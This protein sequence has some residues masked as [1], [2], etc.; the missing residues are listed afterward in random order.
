MPSRAR[1]TARAIAIALGIGTLGCTGKNDAAPEPPACGRR[2]AC[3]CVCRGPC[4]HRADHGRGS[5]NN[6]AGSCR[7]FTRRRMAPRRNVI[8]LRTN[9]TSRPR[10]RTRD[11]G[12]RHREGHCN[13]DVRQ[14]H[15]A[16]DICHASGSAHSGRHRRWLS[17]RKCG[18]RGRVTCDHTRRRTSGHPRQIMRR[19]IRDGLTRARAG[20]RRSSHDAGPDDYP[21]DIRGVLRAV[22]VPV[23]ST[24]F[25]RLFQPV[26]HIQRSSTDLGQ[27]C[28]R[29]RDNPRSARSRPP[30]WHR[31][32]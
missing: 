5:F 24:S 27:S 8:C 28:L 7:P 23:H 2:C 1:A 4:R 10:Q 26:N 11:T 6:P 9:S 13:T 14:R 19:E 12:A 25:G 20:Q 15:A 3:C 29:S 16:Q 31:A 32:Q 30:V 18:E 17:I 21:G 22:S